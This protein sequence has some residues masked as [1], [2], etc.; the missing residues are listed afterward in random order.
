MDAIVQL[1]RNALCCIK[2]LEWFAQSMLWDQTFTRQYYRLP[3]PLDKTTPLEILISV[4]QYY[5]FFSCV[6]SGW[7]MISYSLGK[8]H[9]IQRILGHRTEDAR[10]N[11]NKKKKN[12]NNELRTWS[13]L[14]I[15]ESLATESALALR[16]LFIGCN[17]WFIG[18]SFFW[19]FA[20]SWHITDTDWLG[21]LQGLIH[22]LTV[23]EIC[24]LPLL[25]Y[26]WID[27]ATQ[28]RKARAMSTLASDLPN[29]GTAAPSHWTLE[30]VQWLTEWD[31]YWTQGV[32]LFDLDT[33]DTTAELAIKDE[34]AV[35]R[36]RDALEQHL[37]AIVPTS[38]TA[39]ANSD[40]NDDKHSKAQLQQALRDKAEELRLQAVVTKW[41]GYREYLYFWLNFFAFY[42]YL[43]GIL[44]YYYQD[45]DDAAGDSAS[46]T[47]PTVVRH[48]KL[49]MKNT[50]ADW[51]GNFVGDLMWTLE[52][53]I[54]LLST[55]LFQRWRLAATA[56]KVKTD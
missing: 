55:M 1:I 23:M 41:E 13:N 11:S 50:D 51:R 24:L 10:N 9:R 12:N 25:Y 44:A 30:Q 29:R 2:D 52:P 37:N 48:L 31:P 54:I 38:T 14:L 45:D 27:G 18:M 35:T 34:T 15:N 6:R 46:P 20:N 8:F 21:G 49:G 7:N 19:L 47:I 39:T 53:A 56:K 17:V 32:S 43:L 33:S 16:S 3:E 22:A 5:A 28:L 42:G 40:S 26:M 36:E 4:T